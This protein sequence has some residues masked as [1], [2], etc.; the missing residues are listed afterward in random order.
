MPKAAGQA[1]DLSVRGERVKLTLP[2]AG[3]FQVLNAVQALGLALVTGVKQEVAIQ[4]LPKLY[5]RA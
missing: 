3:E 2:L 5:G 4:A 1:L